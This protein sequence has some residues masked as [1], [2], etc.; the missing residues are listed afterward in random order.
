M[1]TMRVVLGLALLV[2]ATSW[3]ADHLAALED[4]L[5]IDRERDAH[6]QPAA[7]MEFAGVQPGMT[8]LDV[9]AAGGWYSE[10]LSVAVGPKGVVYADN[11][12]WLLDAMNGAPAKALTERLKDGRLS[13]VLRSD[14]GLEQGKI[15]AASIDFALTALNFHDTYYNAGEEAA[16]EQL[17]LVFAALKPGG[18]F[19]LIDHSGAADADNARLHRIPQAIVLEL[20]TRAGFILEAEGEMLKHPEDDLSKMVFGKDIRGKTDRFVLKLRKPEAE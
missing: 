2:S 15:K 4:R 20:A 13:N 16:L 17:G 8:V 19:V 14:A 10:V 12:R 7:V 6:R 18:V 5:A 11:P 1:K 9:M 3:S